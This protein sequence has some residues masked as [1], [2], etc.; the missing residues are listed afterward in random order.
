M[1]DASELQCV[2]PE[3]SAPVAAGSNCVSPI[4]YDTV[5]LHIKV[6]VAALVGSCQLTHGG[7]STLADVMEIDS[8]ALR[9]LYM[10]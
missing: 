5:L 9:S 4:I 8:P 1:V 7:T 3:L 10:F 2:L 6:R